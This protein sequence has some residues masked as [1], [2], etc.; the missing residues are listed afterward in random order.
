M[1]QLKIAAAKTL[2]MEGKV[3]RSEGKGV[4][5]HPATD[6]LGMRQHSNSLIN[7]YFYSETVMTR[8]RRRTNWLKSS[9][10]LRAMLRLA[11]RQ[12]KIYLRRT[13]KNYQG[14]LREIS[15]L[16]SFLSELPRL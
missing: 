3:K 5:I 8:P 14:E 7:Y 11:R 9:M 13:G 12:L 6:R 4:P 16:Q 2:V 10:R 1:K 15:K